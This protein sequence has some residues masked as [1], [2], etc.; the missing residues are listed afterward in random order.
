MISTETLILPDLISICP[1]NWSINPHYDRVRVESVAW[2]DSFKA[3]PER[4][5]ASF[6]Q[7]NSEL[8]GALAYSYAGYEEL[9]TSADFMNLLFT[10]DE[11]SDELDG[12]EADKAGAALF[13]A[14]KGEPIDNSV[15]SRIAME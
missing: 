2:I 4:K 15:M 3:F 7:F 6:T 8:L 5:L 12:H 11:I 9:R 10:F 14:L 1:F 13:Q